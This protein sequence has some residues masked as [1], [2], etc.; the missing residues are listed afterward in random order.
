MSPRE[1][2]LPPL[3]FV[4]DL[5][6]A[7]RY[8]VEPV[9]AARAFLSVGGRMIS[10][11][12]KGIDDGS[13]LAVGRE[14]A[15]LMHSVG[16]LMIVH[17]RPDLAWLLDA[18]GVHLP[19]R[20]LG[21]REVRQILGRDFLIGRSCHD[22]DEARKADREGLAW[23]TLS[24]V[25]ESLSKPGYAPTLSLQDVGSITSEVEPAVYALGGVTPERVAECQRVGVDGV[26]VVGAILGASNP[27]VATQEL[28]N[29]VG[30][31]SPERTIC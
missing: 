28:L 16:G 7:R 2:V 14:V 25:F 22:A 5:A 15:A 1:Q 3:Y 23:I 12:S 4:L 19:A 26:A 8:E 24:P 17:G 20:G 18:D 9:E 31:A 11:R 30:A 10:L 29:A 21:A 13:A 6:A 27:A